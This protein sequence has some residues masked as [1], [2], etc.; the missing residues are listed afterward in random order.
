MVTSKQGPSH[1]GN[2][3]LGPT[4]A[5]VVKLNKV[6][7]PSVCPGSP[8]C[9]GSLWKFLGPV[10]HCKKRWF[11]R[12]VNWSFQSEYTTSDNTVN[13]AER[14]CPPSWDKEERDSLIH[15]W[16]YNIYIHEAKCLIYLMGALMNVW[17]KSGLQMDVKW[18]NAK[19][20][21]LIKRDMNSI[22]ILTEMIKW[23][24]THP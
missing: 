2:R 8:V 11:W 3:S 18:C 4:N 14:M 19:C 1:R 15:I 23:G 9:R 10:V 7:M 21:N 20:N 6:W 16:I 5:Q 17:W 22:V 24:H 13:D 12:D